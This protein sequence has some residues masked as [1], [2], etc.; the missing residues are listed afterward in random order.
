VRTEPRFSAETLERVVGVQYEV[1]GKSSDNQWYAV[2]YNGSQA[3]ILRSTN[4]ALTG[5]F[6]DLPVINP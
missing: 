3:W 2:D 1:L 6:R 4:V 5:N